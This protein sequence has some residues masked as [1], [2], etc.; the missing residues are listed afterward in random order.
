[1]QANLKLRFGVG[2]RLINEVALQ[3]SCCW[4]RGRTFGAAQLTNRAGTAMFQVSS[5]VN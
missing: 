3:A 4:R 2:I 5:L 1:M